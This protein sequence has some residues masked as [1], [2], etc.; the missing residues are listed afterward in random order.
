MN[1]ARQR[2][3][4]FSRKALTRDDG[5]GK[6]MHLQNKLVPMREALANMEAE[7]GL[8]RDALAEYEASLKL[9][10]NRYRASACAM[11]AAQASGD[12]GA[13]RG[14]AAKL[15]TLAGTGDRSRPGWTIVQHL[16]ATG[17]G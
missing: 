7:P 16:K 9:A 10:P 17:R 3:P 12:V 15:T 1:T 4:G 6:H 2:V 8:P 13:A 11:A 5:H 14:W